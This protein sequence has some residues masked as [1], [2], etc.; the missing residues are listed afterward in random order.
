MDRRIMLAG[1]GLGGLAMAAPSQAQTPTPRELA[2]QFAATLSAHDME[3][4]AALYAEDLV[5]HQVSAAAPP[6]PSG[7]TAKLGSVGFF[8]ARLK[9]M[10][11][12]KVTIEA[13]VASEDHCAAS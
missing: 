2:E 7:I 12:L 13:L 1:L 6:P 8:T 4:F 5:N 3:A 11:D 10:P 9:G